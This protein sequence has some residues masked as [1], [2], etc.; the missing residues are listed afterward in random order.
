LDIVDN[1]IYDQ[2]RGGIHTGTDVADPGGFDGA[3]GSAFVTIS[4]NKVYGNGQSMYGGGIDVRHA[5]G[6]IYNN[7]VY[8]NHRGG[9]RFGDWITDII[10]N[11]VSD[12]GNA[13]EDLGGGIIYDDI[14]L[15]DA[16]NDPPDGNPPASL[17]IRNNISTFNRKAGIRAC[18]TMTVPE[19][20]DYNLV[21]GN[22]P[23][24]DLTGAN[25][26]DC[27]W[28]TL[29]RMSCAN[30]QYGGCGS[31]WDHWPNLIYPNDIMM[32]PLFVNRAGD[33]YQLQS[34]SPAITNPGDDGTQR[35]AYGGM[36]PIDW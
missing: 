34:G 30:Q 33:N 15:D 23:W 26:P 3:A 2:I 13:T 7:L 11:T 1:A 9:I 18:F 8:E 31:D 29:D 4:K 22:F 16:V 6:T 32:D 19:E 10:N 21:Y 20:R 5:S 35:G 25:E 17:F 27:G 36:D 24:S 14:S 28:P 12:N